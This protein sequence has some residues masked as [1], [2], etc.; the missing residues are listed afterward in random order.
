MSDA[1]K[2]SIDL[3]ENLPNLPLDA[4]LAGVMKGLQPAVKWGQEDASASPNL[5][6]KTVIA[7]LTDTITTLSAFDIPCPP[8]PLQGPLWGPPPAPRVITAQRAVSSVYATTGGQ[9]MGCVTLQVAA[10]AVRVWRASDVTAVNQ[11][12]TLS[13]TARRVSAM[14]LAWLT[15]CAVPVASV[16]AF[17]TMG[18]RSVTNVRQA[19]M[20]T[21]TALPASAHGKAHMAT[22]VTHCRVSA[23][24]SLGWW[25]SSVTAVTLGFRSPSAQPP[26]VC[27]TQQEQRSL[28]LERAPA[29]AYQT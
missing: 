27:V 21:Q 1:L 14:A 24:V 19:T 23:C 17:P 13:Q 7:V 6:E 2:V 26:S 4:G 22:H 5:L 18:D 3:T 20:D 11:D 16:F 15:A 10:C 29:A 25:A 8:N 12:T 28:I 9:R